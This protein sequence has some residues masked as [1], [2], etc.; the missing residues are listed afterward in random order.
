[1]GTRSL[2][3]MALATA[4][5]VVIGHVASLWCGLFL[6]DHAH[7]A[8]LRNGDW[9]YRSAVDA[10]RLG[11]VG[12][13]IDLWGRSEA[14][15]RFYRPVAFWLMR[16]QYVL[17]G[18]SPFGMHV[19]SLLWHWTAAMLVGL[20]AWRMTRQAVWAAVASCLM[21]IHPGHVITVQW[22]ACQT[23]LLVAVFLL[24]ATLAYARYADWW[25][26]VP[27]TTATSTPRPRRAVAS[28]AGSLGLFALAL[29]C[30]EHAVMWPAAIFAGDIAFRRFS[31]RRLPAYGLA[32]GVVALYLLLR[33]WA[34]GGFPLPGRPYLVRPGDPEFFRHVCEKFVYYVIGLFGYIPVLP[35]G[36]SEFFAERRFTFYG[37][38]A[39]SV[40]IVVLIGRAWPCRR[41][42][43][44]P[45]AWIVLF[46]APLLPVFASNHHLYLPSAGMAWLVAIGFAALAGTVPGRRQLAA[47]AL[48]VANGIGLPFLTWA[49]GWTYRSAILVEDVFVRDVLESGRTIREGD[50]LFFIN[51]PYNAYYAI[52]ALK[53]AISL[54]ELHGHVLTF[55]PWFT[56][57]AEPG[58]VEVVDDQ[59][60][61]VAAPPG[62]GNEY[63]GGA[64][65][66]M[67]LTIMGYEKPFKTGDVVRGP[68]F[69][70]TFEDA[71][72]R[73]V[74][75]LRFRFRESIHAPGRH[76]FFGSPVRWAYPLF[77]PRLTSTQPV[78]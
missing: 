6:D 32:A 12:E 77:D 69:D 57:M 67:I 75:R 37:T 62:E 42:L 63:L 49:F 26:D 11:I 65:G 51:F 3:T 58:T 64:G 24:A 2:A 1:M 19:F 35:S 31:L 36:W 18:W 30:R 41:Q 50:H 45:V 43:L 44:F 14:G 22:I 74:R 39:A 38:F 5:F 52:P 13:V 73:G 9:S 16:A 78:R 27:P 23:E 59:T 21:A 55:S 76:F 15:L 28:L 46:F 8:N 54:K 48:V 47:A 7:Y 29:G 71:D 10:A 40:L 70:V 34:L 72:E 61:V 66:R 68:L 25:S 56:R 33:H 60:L 20:L 17:V 4:A 53:A